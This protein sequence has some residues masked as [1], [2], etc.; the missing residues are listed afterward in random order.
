MNIYNRKNEMR[1]EVYSKM[2]KKRQQKPSPRLCDG[3]IM[4]EWME[5][6]SHHHVYESRTF[7]ERPPWYKLTITPIRRA[8]AESRDHLFFGHSPQTITFRVVRM[9]YLWNMKHI[10][11]KLR[12]DHNAR[13][14]NAS[15]KE[16]Y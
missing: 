5:Y 13:T 15:R 2:L 7:S 16:R 10:R 11:N 1:R 8:L 4:R 12:C 14:L 6:K 9:L 3:V